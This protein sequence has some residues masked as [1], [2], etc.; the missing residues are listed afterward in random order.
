MHR[1]WNVR[2]RSDFIGRTW[3]FHF[4]QWLVLNWPF[5]REYEDDNVM[6]LVDILLDQQIHPDHCRRIIPPKHREEQQC[7]VHY[8]SPNWSMLLE[9]ASK[10]RLEWEK[11]KGNRIHSMIFRSFT[12]Q[13]THAFEKIDQRK[14]FVVENVDVQMKSIKETRL[15][16]STEGMERSS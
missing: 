15:T 6:M 2:L 16:Y 12:C 5:C 11:K 9:F 4:D 13:N 1:Q 10:E 14:H 7:S 3:V 8:C